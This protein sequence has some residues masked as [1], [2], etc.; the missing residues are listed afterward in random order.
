[1][2]IVA[3]KKETVAIQLGKIAFTAIRKGAH[4]IWSAINSCFGSGQWR[5]DKPWLYKDKWKY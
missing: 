2:G 5:P 1:M 3:R 4:L